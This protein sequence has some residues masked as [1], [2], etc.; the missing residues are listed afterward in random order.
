MSELKEIK[1]LLENHIEKSNVQHTEM[2]IQ[3]SKIE[4][5]QTFFVKEQSSQESRIKESEKEIKSLNKWKW[6]NVGTAILAFF[7]LKL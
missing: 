3:L 1:T 7:G 4:T 5:T 6:M 2:K